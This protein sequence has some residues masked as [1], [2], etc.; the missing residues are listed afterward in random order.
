VANDPKKFRIP[1]EF[2][3]FGHRY[4][5]IIDDQLFTRDNCYG[6]ADDD[7]RHIKIQK[8]GTVSRKDDVEEGEAEKFTSIEITD[9]VILETFY[10]ELTHIIFD[11]LGEYKLSQKE[12]LVNMIGKA[13]LEVYLSSAYEEET[14]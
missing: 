10:H 6:Q 5:V 2:T 12:R 14:K 1:K 11:A 7:A 3:L 8:K 13:M 4:S 9:E